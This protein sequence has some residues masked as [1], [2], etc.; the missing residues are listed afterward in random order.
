MNSEEVD[1]IKSVYARWEPTYDIENAGYLALLVERD[2]R[3]ARLLDQIPKKMAQ[4]RVLDVGC[5]YGGL[6]DMFHKR[7]VPA[8]SLFGIDLLPNRVLAARER[9]PWFTFQEGNAEEL[10]FPDGWF[11]IVTVFTVFS[12]ILDRGMA[13]NV[14]RGITR[15][16]AKGG[17]IIWYDMRYPNPWNRNVRPMTK[18]GIQELFPFFKLDLNSLTVLPPLARRLGRGTNSIYP[19]LATVPIFHSHYLGLLHSTPGRAPD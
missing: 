18:A 19:L 3:L 12:S 11:D 5:G 2:E 16:L 13:A 6:L 4:C 7:G 15:V 10:D 1:R 17:T 14:A 8:D 9:Y